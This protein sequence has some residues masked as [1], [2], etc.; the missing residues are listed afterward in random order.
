QSV[1]AAY[2]HCAA[3]TRRA[4]SNFYWGFRLLPTER[5]R[6]LTAVYA[7]CRAADDMAD[8][9]GMRADPVRMIARWRDELHAAYAGRPTHPIGVAPADTVE[10]F[11]VP[12][13]HF[14]AGA[15]GGEM[16]LRRTRYARWDG[17]LSEYCYRVASA[18]GL[19]AIEIFGYTNPSAREYAVNLGLAFQLTNILRDVAEDGARGR[20]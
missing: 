1:E 11:R 16:D 17:D 5:R 14:D 12:R 6:G 4:H 10:R 13:A 9:P 20:I 2:E 15:D 19:I 8:D 3:V 18:V 7:F